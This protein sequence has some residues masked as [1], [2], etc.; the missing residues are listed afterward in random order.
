V[1]RILGFDPTS[2]WVTLSTIIII[3]IILFVRR[4]RIRRGSP[5]IPVQ[6]E[7]SLERVGIKSPKILQR[8]ARYASISPLSRAYLELNHALAR[9]GQ[10][11]AKADTPS[12]RG[13][14]LVQRLPLAETPVQAVLTPYQNSIY[15]NQP[16]DPDEAQSAGK[17]IRKLS[18]L[19]RLQ[20]FLARFQDPKR[21]KHSADI[22]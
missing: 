13:K 12:E 5:P 20:R 8:W 11:P 15:G 1:A 19:A 18:Y 4:L 14:D 10:P 22:T 6:I 9:L 16:S 21:K 7:S 3:S 2:I 17:E